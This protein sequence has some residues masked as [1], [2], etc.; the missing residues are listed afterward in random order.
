MHRAKYA[1]WQLEAKQRKDTVE[2][3]E[4]QLTGLVADKVCLPLQ[5]PSVQDFRRIVKHSLVAEHVFYI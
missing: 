4:A 1:N 5:Y 2:A 3:V